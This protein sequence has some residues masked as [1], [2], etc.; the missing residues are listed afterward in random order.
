MSG[1][2]QIALTIALSF[3]FGALGGLL[4]G[5]RGGYFWTDESGARRIA[6]KTPHE[7]P[8]IFFNDQNGSPKAS[9]HLGND[10][11]LNFLQPDGNGNPGFLLRG[12]NPSAQ[13]SFADE[14]RV[15]KDFPN[16]FFGFYGEDEKAEGVM[17]I[18]SVD[19]KSGVVSGLLEDGT[20]VATLHGPSGRI[21]MRLGED[22]P[23]IELIDREG[24][25]IWSAP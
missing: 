13:V 2:R 19:G 4:V 9:I 25:K 12:R 18:L 16:L 5:H 8:A 14:G 17:R 22:G 3:L 6:I 15:Q 24:K 7:G 20:P 21:D 1:F 11:S 23:R 10:N